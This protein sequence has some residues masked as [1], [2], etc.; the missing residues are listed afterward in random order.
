M[1]QK[2]FTLVELLVGLVIAMLCMIM[3]LMLFKQTTQIGISSSQDAEYDAQIQTGLLVSQ[4]FIQN[5]GYGSGKALD[6]KTGTYAG[7]ASLLWRLIPNIGATPITYQCQGIAEKVTQDGNAFMHRLV[8]IKKTCN[9]TD[10]WETG[11]WQDDQVIVAFRSNKADPVFSYTL[12][13]GQCTPFGIDK[14]ADKGLRQVTINARR[15]HLNGS[16]KN[17]ICLNNILDS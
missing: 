16:I 10:T 6:I 12:T 3:M 7:N 5:A 14:S 15:E 8:L 2:G 9:A 4:K 11:T 1:H 17:T 13:T